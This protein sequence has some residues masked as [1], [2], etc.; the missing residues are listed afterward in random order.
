MRCATCAVNLNGSISLFSELRERVP[1][2]RKINVNDD[3]HAPAGGQPIRRCRYPSTSG[4]ENFREV[5]SSKVRRLIEASAI[6]SPSADIVIECDEPQVLATP[7][8]TVGSTRDRRLRRVGKATR[9]KRNRE[10]T[11]S[12]I[13]V[14]AQSVRAC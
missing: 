1:G 12:P 11:R 10:L 2:V 4:T 14:S 3:R 13:R 8:D 9:P 5:A 7:V 6:F